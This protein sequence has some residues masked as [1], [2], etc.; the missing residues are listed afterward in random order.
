[1]VC[2]EAA[3]LGESI[4]SLKAYVDRFVIIDAAFLHSPL[5]LEA[6]HSTDDTRAVATAAC[7]AHPSKPLHY[8]ESAA[9]LPQFYA[10]NAYLE[11]IQP[12][13]WVFVVDGDEVFYGD[14]Y[15]ILATFAAIRE[16]RIN[17]SLALP[18]YTTA[19]NV[20]KMADE[21]TPDEFTTA[22]IIATMGY[23]PRLFAAA[24]N[25]RYTVPAGAS[26]PALTFL[27]DGVTPGIGTFA[28][29]LG[30]PVQ[31]LPNQYLWPVHNAPPGNLFLINHHSR[32]S[33][34]GYLDDYAWATE[35][36]VKK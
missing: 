36:V 30:A 27:N 34:D 35:Q 6:T 22:P 4:R 5:P 3:S 16:G 28:D 18:V 1:V 14:H 9:R 32:Q 8:V 24:T 26:T 25:L 12:P 29:P 33:F 21:V 13:D 11:F 31:R 10:R 23:M 7:A 17:H 19:I 20:D 15:E 2:N